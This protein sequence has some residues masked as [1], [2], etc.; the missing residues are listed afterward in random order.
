MNAGLL[1]GERMSTLHREA[2]AL[3]EQVAAEDVTRGSELHACAEWEEV[4]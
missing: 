1:S 3:H 2:E 4:Q